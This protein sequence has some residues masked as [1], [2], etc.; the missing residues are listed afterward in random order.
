MLQFLTYNIYYITLKYP[1]LPLVLT[2]F[3]PFLRPYTPEGNS[4]GM[5]S[6]SIFAIDHHGAKFVA[7]VARGELVEF[8]A[9][10]T[11]VLDSRSYH[12]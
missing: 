9:G 3:H 4:D 12:K 11:K 8:G 7:R 10:T 1:K 6:H 2:D 5:K